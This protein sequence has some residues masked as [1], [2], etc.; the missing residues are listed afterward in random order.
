MS[1]EAGT[2]LTILA[3]FERSVRWADLNSLQSLVSDEG[4]YSSELK[5]VVSS[6]DL[7]QLWKN[8]SSAEHQLWD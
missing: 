1:E 5:K 3:Q 8:H 2:I 6:A 4:I 7:N